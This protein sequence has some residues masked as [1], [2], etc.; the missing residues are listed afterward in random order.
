[1]IRPSSRYS[2]PFQAT[3]IGGSRGGTASTHPP[4]QQDQ[5]LSFS[6][7]FLP[8]SVRFRGWRPPTGRRP[9]TGNPGS[10]TDNC[11]ICHLIHSLLRLISYLGT[12]SSLYGTRTTCFPEII[13]FRF[14]F[15]VFLK[16]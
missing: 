1:M 11:N 10:A 9:P 8:K 4:P 12:C 16:L 7:T 6:H 3:T 2:P 13:V 5:F 14:V 15:I